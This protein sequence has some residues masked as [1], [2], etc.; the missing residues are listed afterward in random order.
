MKILLVE[1]GLKIAKAIENGLKIHHYSV[2]VAY[3]GEEALAVFDEEVYDLVIL[4]WML[5][6]MDGIEVLKELRKKNVQIPVLMLT[7]KGEVEDKIHGLDQGADDYLS[8]PFSFDEVLARIKALLRRP[9]TFQSEVYKYDNLIL[10]INKAIL[11]VNNKKVELSY[12]EFKLLS[13]LI[14]NKEIVI[15]KSRII[16]SVWNNNSN[17]QKNTVEAYIKRLRGKLGKSKNLIKTVRGTGYKL[18]VD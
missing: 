10:D 4:D 5:P 8:K 9:K 7:A 11:L 3:T 2:D 12:T 14:R 13:F 18:S 15:E 6:G 1:D 16:S 17:I